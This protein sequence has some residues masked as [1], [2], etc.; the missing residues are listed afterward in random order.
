MF[1]MWKEITQMS[2]KTSLDEQ[3]DLV[4]EAVSA[5]ANLIPTP[6]TIWGNISKAK[7]KAADGDTMREICKL[8]Y[9][10]FNRFQQAVEPAT[11]KMDMALLVRAVV[12][13]VEATKIDGFLGGE[14]EVAK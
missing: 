1:N 6:E 14:F 8:S 9:D 2:T 4:D 12:F 3:E 13:K 10:D 11:R 7:L 5:L